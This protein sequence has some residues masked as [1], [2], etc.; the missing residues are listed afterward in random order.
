MRH[1]SSGETG[2]TL[3]ESRLYA[4]NDPRL[5]AIHQ[6]SFESIQHLP[7]RA[8]IEQCLNNPN[9]YDESHGETSDP[10]A[11]W[12][13]QIHFLIT[14][15]LNLKNWD[16]LKVYPALGTAADKYHGVDFLLRF[17]DPKTKKQYDVT[18][19]I[20]GNKQGKRGGYK[21]DVIATDTGAF[22]S[23]RYPF[24]EGI[25]IPD[26]ELSTPEE[27]KEIEKKRQEAAASVI[28]GVLRAK[29]SYQEEPTP[30]AQSE[31]RRPHFFRPDR[32]RQTA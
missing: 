12:I 13:R 16:D 32:R 20:T 4:N 26:L 15:K 24:V 25:D 28:F 5:R 23:D 19:D 21:A 11:E 18:V 29:I 3:E 17:T 9:G 30:L 2:R 1:H 14:Q 7:Y 22:A 27:D 8:A 6:I 31:Q 10:P